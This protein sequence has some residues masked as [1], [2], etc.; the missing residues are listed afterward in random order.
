MTI[1]ITINTAMKSII[2]KYI[3]HRYW[4]QNGFP[5]CDEI[6]Q[7]KDAF[8]YR[9]SGMPAIAVPSPRTSGARW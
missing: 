4:N 7:R 3:A 2:P 6:Q 1:N 8:P 9:L 5:P